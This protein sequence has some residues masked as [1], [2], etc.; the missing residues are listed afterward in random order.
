MCFLL[1][2]MNTIFRKSLFAYPAE[3][4][5]ICIELHH[6]FPLLCSPGRV[7]WSEGHSAPYKILEC[8]IPKQ[9]LGIRVQLW[10][11]ILCPRPVH[12]WLPTCQGAAACNH[13]IAYLGPSR[14]NTCIRKPLT[15]GNNSAASSEA[16]YEVSRGWQSIICPERAS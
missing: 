12:K 5:G 7:Y 4:A 15:W 2:Y 11:S 13:R 16:G 10:W 1:I 3:E 6:P 9:T 8:W 14:Q